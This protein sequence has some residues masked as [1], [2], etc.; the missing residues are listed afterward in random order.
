MLENN[1]LYLKMKITY[2][3]ANLSTAALIIRRS[4]EIIT[5]YTNTDNKNNEN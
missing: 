4:Y 2:C 1:K 3:N 5:N